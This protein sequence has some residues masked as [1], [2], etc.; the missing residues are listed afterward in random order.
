MNTLRLTYKP[1]LTYLLFGMML[2]L[3]LS[4]KADP[5]KVEEPLTL[6]ETIQLAT[7]NQPLLQSL[8]DAAASSR[9]AASS[10]TSAHIMA[11]NISAVGFVV[12]S[13]IKFIKI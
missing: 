11:C 10:P 12:V 6:A 7:Q 1:I 9:Q 13:D 3:A 5:A 8:D 2:L 4:L